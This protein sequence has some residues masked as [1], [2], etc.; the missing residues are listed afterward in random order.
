MS[1]PAG[2]TAG[3]P[4]ARQCQPADAPEPQAGRPGSPGASAGRNGPGGGG[5]RVDRIMPGQPAGAAGDA[6]APASAPG[7]APER[8]DGLVHADELPDGLVIADHVG[9]VTVF[10]RA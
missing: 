9:Q 7:P 6:L 2:V 8:A 3:R 1:S 4:R 10:N 5:V